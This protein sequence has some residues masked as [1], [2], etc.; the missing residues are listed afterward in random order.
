MYIKFSVIISFNDGIRKI[1]YKIC[2]RHEILLKLALNTKQS[3]NQLIKIVGLVYGS[4]KT[5]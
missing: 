3:N 2:S 4:Q 1:I 5:F